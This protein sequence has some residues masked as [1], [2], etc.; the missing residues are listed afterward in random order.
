MSL[1]IKIPKKV[2]VTASFSTEWKMWTLWVR[3]N[4]NISGALEKHQP[5]PGEILVKK[6]SQEIAVPCFRTVKGNVREWWA[7]GTCRTE[8]A[9]IAI[10]CYWWGWRKTKLDSNC[11][12]FC[13]LPLHFCSGF[14]LCYEWDKKSLH[15]D[16]F[17]VVH[18][19]TQVCCT[20]GTPP[21]DCVQSC[22]VFWNRWFKL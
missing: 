11:A 4:R 17:Q 20:L 6:L 12:N 8:A 5:E 2:S 1:K 13:F 19:P 9:L 21:A 10:I 14:S 16:V 18:D 7:P 3:L 15:C 22:C